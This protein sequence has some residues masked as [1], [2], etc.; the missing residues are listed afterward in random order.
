VYEL[1]QIIYGRSQYSLCSL[2][3]GFFLCVGIRLQTIPTIMN[4]GIHTLI[5]A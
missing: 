1:D 2:P 5:A 3:A 4:N